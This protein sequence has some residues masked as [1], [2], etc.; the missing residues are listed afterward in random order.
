M[1]TKDMPS[2]VDQN[3]LP[4]GEVRARFD[5]YR[6]SVMDKFDR[7]TVML[8]QKPFKQQVSAKGYD[9]NTL[10]KE[11]KAEGIDATPPG[12]RT[13]LG[14]NTGLKLGQQYVLGIN[15]NHPLMLGHL[16][17]IEQTAGELTL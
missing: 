15:L 2:A 17:D 4:R 14:R 11:V 16:E 7:G 1:H 9:F 6:N 5:V 3:R 13:W 8:V 10:R 12:R